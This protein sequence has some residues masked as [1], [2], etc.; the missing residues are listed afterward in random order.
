M[1]Y[2][3]FQGL[4]LELMPYI[5][6]GVINRWVG[7]PLDHMITLK[8]VIFRLAQGHFYENMVAISTFG[9]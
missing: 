2:L 7:P 3:A 6:S 8:V 5:I 9:R 4:L 1:N